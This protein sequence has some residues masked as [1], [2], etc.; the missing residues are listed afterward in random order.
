MSTLS[1]DDTS[2]TAGS[3]AP[4]ATASGT[5]RR[6]WR[7]RVSPV[8]LA[9]LLAAT[10]EALAW[11]VVLPPLEGPDEIGHFAYTERLVETRSI[12]WYRANPTKPGRATSTETYAAALYSGVVAESRNPFAR[13]PGS[14][15]SVDLWRRQP[16]RRNHADRADGGYTSAM[17]TPPLYYLYA[18]VPYLATYPL[19]F[20]DREFAM[21]LANIPL[22]LAIVALTWAIA[23]MLLPRR[24]LQ[25]LATAA[26]ALNPQLTHLT[27]VVNPDVFLAAQWAA[28]FYLSLLV[29]MRGA[30][31]WRVAGIVALSAAS[32]L[33][34][35][36]GVAILVPAAFV[37][38]AAWWRWRRPSRRTARAVLSAGAVAVLAVGYLTL[39]YATLGFLTADSARRF[40]GY[41]WQFYLPK[42]SFMT[43]TFRPDWTAKNAF[44]DRFYGTFA[45]LE[46]YFS[47]GVMTLLARLTAAAIVLALVGLAVRL[48]SVR[49][50]PTALL[51]LGV[52]VVGALAYILDLHVAAYRS[53][54][55]GTGDPVVTGRYL[56]P[57]ITIYGLGVALAVSWLPRRVAGVAGGV[58]LGGLALLQLSAMGILFERFYA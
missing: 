14:E 36:R 48:R 12:P 13:P 40:G 5:S 3:D 41:L 9:L 34:H 21:R 15:L 43:P 19:D 44:I 22:L 20:F 37:L 50:R 6:R 30:T 39:R 1:R 31:R 27:A 52:F 16:P 24:S 23:G 10:V 46:V 38:A 47:P 7:R 54:A 56:L 45:Q 57:L 33:T 32:C 2:S 58:V 11:I 28:F 8:L 26:V 53:L 42:L 4:R 51:A 49:A 55:A 35:G 17:S 18:A 29:V 25:V